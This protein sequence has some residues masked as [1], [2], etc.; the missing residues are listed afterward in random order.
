MEYSTARRNLEFK[1]NKIDTLIEDTLL[2]KSIWKT[3]GSEQI[4]NELERLIKEAD[5][6]LNEI[7][8]D[9]A[10]QPGFAINFKSITIHKRV[11]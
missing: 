9:V 10:S 3:T 8:H 1:N 6:I 2:L 7:S 4:I 5:E 11:L